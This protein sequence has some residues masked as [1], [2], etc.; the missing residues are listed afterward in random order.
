MSDSDYS[1]R[2][3]LT[4]LS[5]DDLARVKELSELDLTGLNETAIREQ[6]LAPLLRILG[7][8]PKDDYQV[9]YEDTF[10][11]RD[12]YVMYGRKRFKLDYRFVIWKSGL[13]LLE[14]KPGPEASAESRHFKSEDAQQAFSYSTH[15]D[16]DAPIFAVSNGAITAVFDRDVVGLEPILTVTQEE[17]PAKID[18]LREL[19]AADQVQFYLKRKLLKRIEQVLSSELVLS[20]PDEFVDA[21]RH[22]ATRVR[23]RVHDNFRAN[24]AAGQFIT[25]R[26][27]ELVSGS[28]PYEIIETFFLQQM[29]GG[30]VKRL[31]HKIANTVPVG[32]EYLFF[33]RLL[34]EELRPVTIHYHHNVLYLLGVLAERGAASE[35][36][37]RELRE[38]GRRK[39]PA[40]ELFS[41]WL[42]LLVTGF[43][44]RPELR[45]L[46][47]VEGTAGRISKRLLL[48]PDDQRQRIELQAQIIRFMLA[49]RDVDRSLVSPAAI[50]IRQV[51]GMIL[52]ALAE[53]VDEFYDEERRE[54]KLALARQRYEALL[55][56]E[57]RLDAENYDAIVREL[58]ESWSALI[59]FD[60]INKTYD[61]L[62]AGAINIARE[63]PQFYQQV[64]ETV[65]TEA[66]ALASLNAAAGTRFCE[67]HGIKVEKL[68]PAQMQLIRA[69]RFKF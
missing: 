21:V 67:E 6:F 1:L 28:R 31:C 47:L 24:F 63:F 39:I 11:V 45:V 51:E 53:F 12:W 59:D 34:L 38:G 19:L 18:Q 46:W 20:R 44:A 17:L 8:R 60:S 54:F 5:A 61:L 10:A 62:G 41:W 3:H 2:K 32:G 52:A 58:G 49:E 25:E 33:A 37:P 66:A 29:P 26:W 22:I 50:M 55:A 68:T 43:R 30:L 16:I 23:P 35:Y 4:K 57:K 13:W 40:S 64:S 27:D 9:L 65:K 48:V 7:Y 56:V 36:V 42:D 69:E 15:P 14:A